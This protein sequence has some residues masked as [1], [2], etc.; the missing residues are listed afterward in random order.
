MKRTKILLE[1]H[2]GLLIWVMLVALFVV[3]LIWFKAFLKLI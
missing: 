2:S 3:N 1:E